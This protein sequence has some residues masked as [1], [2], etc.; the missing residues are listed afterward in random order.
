MHLLNIQSSPRGPKSA[1]IAVADAFLQEYRQACPEFTVDTLNVWEENLP[2]FDGGG[3]HDVARERE[4]GS[5][6]RA[7]SGGGKK[8]RGGFLTVAKR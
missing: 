1:S 7:R 2:D 4:E 6:H 8:V 3:R 5:E